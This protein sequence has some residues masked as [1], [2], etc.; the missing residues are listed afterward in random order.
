MNSMNGLGF[1]SVV[2]V[3]LLFLAAVGFWIYA[4][5]D[6]IQV[7]DGVRLRAGDKLIWVLVIVLTGIFGPFL[8]FFFG[9]PERSERKLGR[10]D[11]R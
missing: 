5:V 6:C 11:D 3:L 9:R 2:L 1:M 10:R 7:P 4:L 8:Y